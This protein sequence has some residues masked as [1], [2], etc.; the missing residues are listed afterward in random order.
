MLYDPNWQKLDK[1]NAFKLSSLIGW[2]E[3][4]PP[5][6]SYEYCSSEKCLLAQYFTAAGFK[7][8]EVLFGGFAHGVRGQRHYPGSFDLVAL[9]QFR[10]SEHTF[11]KALKRAREIAEH[12][13][14]S[15]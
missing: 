5:S 9:A 2:L 1:T 6:K 3:K 4:Q 13:A 12:G 8:V 7:R 10:H 14:P 15:W 11:G